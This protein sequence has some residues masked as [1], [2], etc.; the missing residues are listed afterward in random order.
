M[1]ETVAVSLK[2]HTRSRA[3][4]D[5]RPEVLQ[6]KLIYSHLAASQAVAL[7]NGLV[8]A[9]VLSAEVELT[10]IAIWLSALAV[11]TLARIYLAAL[12]RR[13]ASFSVDDV[14]VWRAYFVVGA[15]AAGLVWGSTALLLYPQGSVIHQVFLAFVLG[16]MVLGAAATL[17]PVF[18][19]YVLFAVCVLLPLVGR[20]LAT[21][22]YVHDAM[23]VL[24][25]IFLFAMFVIGKRIHDFIAGS[26]KLQCENRE[27]ITHLTHTGRRAASLN[28]DLIAAQNELRSANQALENRVAERTAAL[29]EA[30]RR[31]D[32][33]LAQLE[34]R[35]SHDALTDLLNRSAFHDALGRLIAHAAR[36]GERLIVLYLDLDRFK[37][38]NDSLGHASG[39]QLLICIAERLRDCVR[40]SDV[41]AR[42]GG[43]EFAV[44]LADTAHVIAAASVAR[45]ILREIEQPATLL[46]QEV[47]TC[48]SIGA[49][50]YPDD[51]LDA[52]TLL[53]NADIA[54]Y[55]AKQKGR[56]RVCFYTEDLNEQA[57][58]R[59]RLES[60]LRRAISRQEFELHYQ[61]RVNVHS[62]RITSV[63]ALVRWRP[64]QGELIGP[65]RFIPLAEETGLIV[66]LGLWVLTTACTQ[67]REWRDAGHGIRVAVNLSARQL[68]EPDF[69]AALSGVLAD[70]G[71]EARYLELE[72][73]E[74]VAMNDPRE[75]RHLLQ[76]ISDL[77][78]SITIDDFGAGHSSLS[79]L[80]SFPIDCLKIDQ[81]FVHGINTDSADESI[82]RSILALGKNLK[83]TLIGEGVESEEQRAFLEAEGCD[84]IQG[85]FCSRPKPAKELIPELESTQAA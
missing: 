42:L 14:P 67:M 36:A 79:Y 44:V 37:V 6:I 20:Y 17:T 56:A 62:R 10:A 15:V 77:G 21:G 41:V 40:H 23:G 81:S 64:A 82:V 16:G 25:V 59:L 83:F 85:F 28:N 49:A 57:N 54:M 30:N 80:K 34:H 8:L 70:C 27:L 48:A 7:A 58:E 24:A 46:A 39:D 71:L 9:I 35:A 38:V 4:E 75:M 45:K 73:S 76:A 65:S 43:D 51:G 26:L 78:V 29:Q 72:I 13:R 84:E 69:V 74:S 50:V 61:P 18:I 5:A 19:A 60:A 47:V 53:K 12:F 1:V 32:E 63:E 66:P 31:K 2:S 3:D 11:T 55:R 22:D 68:R 52:D 33:F